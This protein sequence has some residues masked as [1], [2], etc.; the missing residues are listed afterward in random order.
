MSDP[1]AHE[2]HSGKSLLETMGGHFQGFP[3]NSTN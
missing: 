3:R 1:A 2:L